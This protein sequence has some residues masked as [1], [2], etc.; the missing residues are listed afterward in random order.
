[1][2]KKIISTNDAPAAIGPYSQAV[3]YG[4]LIFC[5]GQ[6][7][8]H[9]QSMEIMSNAASEQTRQAIDN[10]AAVL[11]AAGSDLEKVIKTTIYL[12]NMNDFATVNEVYATYFDNNPPARATIEVSR[13]PKDAL[14][15][16]E[17]IAHK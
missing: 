16:I 10:M 14:V 11:K 2:S 17:C 12:T 3:T 7:A 13:L 5:S 4:D 6:I 1:M 8:L 15:E 9:P